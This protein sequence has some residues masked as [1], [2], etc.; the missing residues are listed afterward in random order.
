MVNAG[1]NRRRK[2]IIQRMKESY[3]KT[4]WCTLT[5]SSKIEWFPESVG[6]WQ[7]CSMSP[8]PNN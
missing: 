1:I 7:G 6:V 5:D 8:S 4:Q 3:N 2:E